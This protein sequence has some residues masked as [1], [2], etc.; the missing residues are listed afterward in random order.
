[1]KYL[2]IRIYIIIYLLYKQVTMDPQNGSKN[3][4]KFLIYRFKIHR[5]S[6]ETNDLLII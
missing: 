2:L 4:L 1:M 3:P 6:I 5:L